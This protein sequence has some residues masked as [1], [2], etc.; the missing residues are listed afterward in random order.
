MKL[1]LSKNVYGRSTN[2]GVR[3]HAEAGD[4][5]P[6]LLLKGSNFI[7]DSIKYPGEHIIIFK[8]QVEEIIE[9][10]EKENE[11]VINEDNNYTENYYEEL[12]E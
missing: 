5:V 6:V 10:T 12:E 2:K 4:V 3:L 8:S 11:K 1:L 7:C 9:E